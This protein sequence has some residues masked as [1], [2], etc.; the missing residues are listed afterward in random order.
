MLEQSDNPMAYINK[1]WENIYDVLCRGDSIFDQM[2]NLFTLCAAIGH[3][4]GMDIKPENRKGI[5][6]WTNLNAESD[7]SVLTTIAWDSQ[8]RDLAVL[9]DRK[10][11]M[12]IACDYAEGGMQ[13]LYENYFEDY[14]QDGQL[15][16]PEKLDIEFSL[17]QIIEG[18]RQNQSVF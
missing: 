13:Y 16:R 3:Q 9:S 6:R 17:A 11:I 18:L 8:K 14:V 2:T 5:F 10:K 4:N 7:I 12:D 15:L 1:N